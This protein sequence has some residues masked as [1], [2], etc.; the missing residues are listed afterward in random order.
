[1]KLKNVLYNEVNEYKEQIIHHGLLMK[2]MAPKHVKDFLSGQLYMNPYS[3]FR[4]L[5]EQISRGDNLDGLEASFRAEQIKMKV[6][7]N[8]G[9][10]VD[11]GG[12]INRVNFSNG[13]EKNINIFSM[14]LFPIVE[15][16]DCEKIMPFDS[17]F[18]DFGKNVVLI[19]E[20]EEFFSKIKNAFNRNNLLTHIP[21]EPTIHRMVEYFPAIYSGRVG[22]FRKFNKYEW[23]SEWRLAFL[24]NTPLQNPSPFR[25]NIGD[26]RSICHVYDTLKL[27]NTGLKINVSLNKDQH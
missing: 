16:E 20:P 1:M 7:R 27:I 22:A 9:D 6:Q 13:Y 17:R 26:I 14:S 10:F 4:G 3:Y 15:L 19:R 5:E 23:Q 12:L 2:F 24:H 21:L 25:F 11:I 18:L 8:N